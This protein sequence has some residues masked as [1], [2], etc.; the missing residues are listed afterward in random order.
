M[1]R[2]SYSTKYNARKPNLGIVPG[3]EELE[4]LSESE[5]EERGEEREVGGDDGRV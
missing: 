3:G 1:K 4:K 5:G 2:N